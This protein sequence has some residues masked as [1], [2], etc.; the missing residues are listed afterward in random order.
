MA[1]STIAYRSSINIQNISK[2]VSSLRKSVS[3]TQKTA[4]KMNSVLG[5]S[6]RNKRQQISRSA[7]IFQK[8]Q[9]ATKRREREDIIEASGIG[10]AAKSSG[11]IVSS[12]TKG[13]LG[14]LFDFVGTL[15]VGWVVN[16]LPTILSLSKV[17]I[18]RVQK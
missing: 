8:R 6:N 13:F 18:K 14:R 4:V 17:A 2:S 12:S 16:N 7:A 10:G 3:G 9:E 1:N 15:M 11:S 5:V